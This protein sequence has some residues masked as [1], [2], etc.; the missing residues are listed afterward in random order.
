MLYSSGHSDMSHLTSLAVKGCE[1]LH[2]LQ[3][4][5]QMSAEGQAHAHVPGPQATLSPMVSSSSAALSAPPQVLPVLQQ[6]A[7]I[8]SRSLPAETPQNASYSNPDTTLGM[9]QALSLS[10]SQQANNASP[11]DHCTRPCETTAE[12]LQGQPLTIGTV[13]SASPNRL[14]TQQLRTVPADLL[15]H[16][17]QSSAT[18]SGHVE[19]A[20]SQSIVLP[21]QSEATGHAA[22]VQLG[23]ARWPKHSNDP[24][25]PQQWQKQQQQQQQQP[26][27]QQQHATTE[28]LSRQR[29]GPNAS[30]SLQTP[31]LSSMLPLVAAGDDSIWP[32]SGKKRSTRLRSSRKRPSSSIKLRSG[33][34]SSPSDLPSHWQTLGDVLQD[35]NLNDI[36]VKGCPLRKGAEVYA[37][38]PLT[39]MYSPFQLVDSRPLAYFTMQSQENQTPASDL[40]PFSPPASFLMSSE[41]QPQGSQ[42]PCQANPHLQHLCQV[43]SQSQMPA[44]PSGQAQLDPSSHRQLHRAH[45]VSQAESTISSS[46]RSQAAFLPLP[47]PSLLQEAPRPEGDHA[48]STQQLAQ[49]NSREGLPTLAGLSQP[50]QV[51]NYTPLPHAPGTS[52]SAQSC[53]PFQAV[54]LALNKLFANPSQPA[55]GSGQSDAQMAALTTAQP[56]AASDFPGDHWQGGFHIPAHQ[57]P[58]ASLLD[59]VWHQEALL[60]PCAASGDQGTMLAIPYTSTGQVAAPGP[61]SAAQQPYAICNFHWQRV[62]QQQSPWSALPM[63]APP[64]NS[65]DTQIAQLPA[66]TVGAHQT[67]QPQPDKTILQLE[68][69]GQAIANSAWKHQPV[70]DLPPLFGT[71]AESPL[72]QDGYGVF[73]RPQLVSS[74]F[75]PSK[76]TKQLLTAYSQH[77]TGTASEAD[78]A[79]MPGFMLPLPCHVQDSS[80]TAQHPFLRKPSLPL[81]LTMIP[82]PNH[83]APQPAPT[84]PP[85]AAGQTRLQPN[86]QDAFELVQAELPGIN[87]VDEHRSMAGVGQAV[88]AYTLQEIASSARHLLKNLEVAGDATSTSAIEYRTSS[89]L[90]CEEV[91][92]TFHNAFLHEDPKAGQ[93][94]QGLPLPE[95][96]VFVSDPHALYHSERLTGPLTAASSGLHTQAHNNT[97]FPEVN[98][99]DHSHAQSTVAADGVQLVKVA[100]QNAAAAETA[101]EAHGPGS[102][103]CV[104]PD[105][106]SD[107]AAPQDNQYTELRAAGFTADEIEESADKAAVRESSVA[108]LPNEADVLQVAALMSGKHSL[109]VED[110]YSVCA[111]WQQTA[112]PYHKVLQNFGSSD[113]VAAC[114]HIQIVLGH[115][116]GVGS[117]RDQAEPWLAS[118]QNL[119]DRMEQSR[120]AGLE[121]QVG[122]ASLRHCHQQ[123]ARALQEQQRILADCMPHLPQACSRSKKRKIRPEWHQVKLASAPHQKPGESTRKGDGHHQARAQEQNHKQRSFTVALPQQTPSPEPADCSRPS[124]SPDNTQQAVIPSPRQPCSSWPA[125]SVQAKHKCALKVVLKPKAGSVFAKP[126]SSSAIASQQTADSAKR[127]L[128]ALKPALPHELPATAS[129]PGT[130]SSVPGAVNEQACTLKASATAVLKGL[131]W[132]D[133]QLSCSSLQPAASPPARNS[134][135]ASSNRFE[136]YRAAAAA[137][138]AGRFV[139]ADRAED[140]TANALAEQHEGRPSARWQYTTGV[141]SQGAETPAP[142]LLPQQ[143]NIGGAGRCLQAE[144]SGQDSMPDNAATWSDSDQADARLES[145]PCSRRTV[146]GGTNKQQLLGTDL[147]VVSAR[148]PPTSSKAQCTASDSALAALPDLTAL[149]NEDTLQHHFTAEEQHALLRLLPKADQQAASAG[150]N[151]LAST[152]FKAAAASYLQASQR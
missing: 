151:P 145:S 36:T 114:H 147:P 126:A 43:H 39:P 49:R 75:A 74:P 58:Q 130:R 78:S 64:E 112:G 32:L 67:R 138:A 109:G 28:P 40:L 93:E 38:A 152:Q 61:I 26:P 4:M 110:L 134:S 35:M 101:D 122:K 141:A 123:H 65:Q 113:P 143:I 22:A 140:D 95:L 57:E 69:P 21:P 33:S 24:Q 118:G 146:A 37:V 133:S 99:T 59:A 47:P 73:D 41:H 31:S 100:A 96:A 52:T 17:I 115:L 86:L 80:A 3:Q 20:S 117:S 1:T 9:T 127:C 42:T 70:S 6:P 15:T 90:M 88:Q 60:A 25:E 68:S 29:T 71:L 106:L 119:I 54:E 89:A 97:G 103:E 116:D 121:E 150:Y 82:V 137:A 102:A 5:L 107:D 7:E 124:H 94:D 131:D 128:V 45:V 34:F 84:C 136:R 14:A 2:K 72:M 16:N 19:P 30:P 55:N 125:A 77:S 48:V 132:A 13:R 135:T 142:T 144:Q 56:D 129:K 149:V 79:A 44:Q 92:G 87:A 111:H 8:I 53:T 66:T 27:S 104:S 18:Q 63:S 62:H 81:A 10:R 120:A 23:L 105:A 11:P 51:A 83:P 46:A 108:D 139:A 148:G 85:D 76:A 91:R 98:A 12:Q 50:L